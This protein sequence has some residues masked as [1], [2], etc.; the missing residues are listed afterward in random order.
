MTYQPKYPLPPIHVCIGGETP[1]PFEYTRRM[2]KILGITH[3]W[4]GSEGH[5]KQ[6]VEKVELYLKNS[7]LPPVVVEVPD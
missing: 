5:A 3:P 7:K 2:H 4:D 6:L 1:D